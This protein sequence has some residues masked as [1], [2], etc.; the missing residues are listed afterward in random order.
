MTYTS[1]AEFYVANPHV[2][3]ELKARFGTHVYTDDNMVCDPE[4]NDEFAGQAVASV[5]YCG[6]ENV[7]HVRPFADDEDD[8]EIAA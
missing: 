4:R 1:Y 5:A 3:A 7:L 6:L 8:F 2:L